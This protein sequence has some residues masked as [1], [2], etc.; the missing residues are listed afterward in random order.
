R[1]C[2]RTSTSVRRDPSGS[3]SSSSAAS[4]A[5]RSNDAEPEWTEPRRPHGTPT[6]ADSPRASD[7]LRLRT[8]TECAG[9][10]A[11]GARGI[12]RT[13]PRRTHGTPT[14]AGSP[15]AAV[16][17]PPRTPPD[18]AGLGA[19]PALRGVRPGP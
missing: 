12:G 15:R 7:A 10:G 5:G 6:H 3:R 2:E 14:H 17:P 16:A 8:P 13:E 1:G 9:L 19:L 4:A 18:A 11:L